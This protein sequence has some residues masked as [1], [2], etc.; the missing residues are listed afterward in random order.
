[1]KLA[2]AAA[3]LSFAFAPTL[4]AMPSDHADHAADLAADLVR[5]A[6]G[7]NPDA[8]SMAVDSLKCA[9]R[10]NASS[11]GSASPRRLAIIDYSLPSAQPRLWVFDLQSRKLLLIERVAHG[12]DSGENTTTRFSND[13]GS[14]QSSLGLYRTS[15]TYTGHNGYSL[16]LDGLEPGFN[17]RAREREIVVHGASYVSEKTI[18]LRGG[19]GRSWGCPAVSLQIAHTLIDAIKD[20]QYLFAYYPDAQWLQHSQLR[21]CPL[22]AGR[23]SD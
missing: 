3:C 5:A 15:D 2:I 22:I 14:H 20:G 13:P 12:R 6:P 11:R 1:M 16:H 17:D 10:A 21:S 7:I 8:V 19:V 9:S 18:G 23:F 4:M